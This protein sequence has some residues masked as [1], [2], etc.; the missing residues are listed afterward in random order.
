MRLQLEQER[1]RANRVSYATTVGTGTTGLSLADA[2]G[3]LRRSAEGHYTVTIVSASATG[4]VLR[5]DGNGT[6]SSG[7]QAG[8]GACAVLE[9]TLSP[10]GE[11]RQPATCW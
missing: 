8:D 1:H 5:A 9:L 10:A 2:V 11:F 3:D 4:Y 6:L 7:R